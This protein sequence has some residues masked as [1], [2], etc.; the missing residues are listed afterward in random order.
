MR[1]GTSVVL[2]LL[3]VCGPA[4]A[5]VLGGGNRATDCSIVF[6]GV[7]QNVGT[8]GVVCADGDPSCDADGVADGTCRFGVSLCTHV[9]APGC[10]SVELSTIR[11][12]G[13]ALPSPPLPS[14]TPGCGTPLDVT[15]SAGTAQ[16]TTLLAHTGSSLKDVDYLNL[17]CVSTPKP[18][19]AAL[20]A[21][22]IDLRDS[23]CR[24]AQISSKLRA[25]LKRA[26][27][28]AAQAAEHPN[29][30]KRLVAKAVKA[31]D[32]MKTISRKI[33]KQDECGDAL[34]LMLTHA[35]GALARP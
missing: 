17:C 27:A 18:Y 25:G 14:A 28:Y 3:A 21:L 22:S 24:A 26:R 16:G 11:V 34:A 9:T 12:A 13:I 4:S 31:L 19:A 5:F 35:Q 2:A 10:G 7:D 32:G 30:A 1:H 6:A 23:G 15:V 29:H 20:C 33:A 8:S